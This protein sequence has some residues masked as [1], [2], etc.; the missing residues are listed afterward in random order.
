MSI[1]E[2]VAIIMAAS[3]LLSALI[4]LRQTA[5]KIR[6]EA[7]DADEAAGSAVESIT[8]AAQRAVDLTLAASETR[9]SDLEKQVAEFLEIITRLNDDIGKYRAAGEEGSRTLYAALCK[10][11][12]YRAENLDWQS[13]CVQLEREF[14]GQID[15]IANLQF[16][17]SQLVAEAAERVKEI[18]GLNRK[19]DAMLVQVGEAAER[20]KEIADLHRKIDV[21]LL[22]NSEHIKEI[23]ELQSSVR[24]LL[25]EN[26]RLVG[27][28]NDADG[29]PA[30]A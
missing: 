15:T 10:I 17:I 18:E 23:A 29:N 7:N 12:D 22:D 24:A 6:H 3:A 19:I 1:G 30:D 20:V 8:E 25:V 16:Q 9:I 11:D 21:L 26:K 4:A 13:K 14:K 28:L 5:A 27:E 2:F